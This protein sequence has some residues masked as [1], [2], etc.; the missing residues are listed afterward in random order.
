MADLSPCAPA[1]Q[2]H[3]ASFHDPIRPIVI[4]HWPEQERYI[5][6]KLTTAGKSPDDI[7]KLLGSMKRSFKSIYP[8][9]DFNYV[10]MDESIRNMYEDE[11]KLSLLV[12]AAMLVTIFISCMGLFGVALFAAEKRTK[13]VSIRKVLGAGVPDL[14]LLLCKDFV[15]L[16]GLSVLIASPLAWWAMNKWLEGFAYRVGLGV[17]VFAIAGLCGM[18]ITVLTVSFQAFRVAN[19]NPVERLR[20]Q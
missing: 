3:T 5:G 12:R 11:Q 15:V 16:V 2:Y 17:P 18:V 4:G 9:R 1:A 19:A 10:F 13:E 14:V 20:T 8:D 6:V 7:H